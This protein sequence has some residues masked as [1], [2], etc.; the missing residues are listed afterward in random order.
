MK[1]VKLNSYNPKKEF[2]KNEVKKGLEIFLS[3]QNIAPHLAESIAEYLL[4][5]YWINRKRIKNIRKPF[6]KKV[7]PGL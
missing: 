2:I 1:I 7:C 5:C 4:S 6:T 3:S